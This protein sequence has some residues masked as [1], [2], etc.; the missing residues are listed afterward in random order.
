MN[1][2]LL[3]GIDVGTHA[4]KG[5]IINTS[6][7]V[8]SYSSKEHRVIIPKPGWA[9]HDANDWWEDFVFISNDLI[10]KS[11]VDPGKIAA[12]GCSA[13][14]PTMMPLDFEGRP[15]R[16]AIL[17]G[18]DN[19]ASCEISM[20]TKKI[21]EKNLLKHNGI[22]LSS[23]SAGPKILWF[24]RN[25]PDLFEKTYKIVTASTYLVYKLT[26]RFFIDYYTAGTFNP[27]FDS[28]KLKWTD[29][30]WNEAPIKL[31]PEIRWT[32]DIA[33]EI[34]KSVAKKTGLKEG[35]KVIVGTA[36]AASE[37][38][39][40]GVVENGDLMIMLGTSAFFIQ[41]VNK[42]V[43]SIKVWPT[44]YLKPGMYAIAAAMSS[45]GAI[46]SWLRELLES[47]TFD[48]IDEMV[49]KSPIGNEGILALPYFSGERTPIN[50][51]SA[52]GSILGL[53]L[54]HKKEHITRAIFE[55]IAYGI[56]D[57]LENIEKACMPIRRNIVIGG[58]TKNRNLMQIISNVTKKEL[59]IPKIN[60]GACFGNAF[61]AG[62]GVG[63]FQSMGDILNWVRWEKSIKPQAEKSSEYDKYYKL[64]KKFYKATSD[65]VHE[66]VDLSK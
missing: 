57:N 56:R 46:I 33:G 19:R 50:D 9:E 61:L 28:H 11:N 41:I 65:I 18:I 5:V 47:Y 26:G 55:S 32:A 62:L 42:F 6:G 66:L 12:V 8:K 59:F 25:E 14:A 22:L 15:L 40:S 51:P 1:D 30:L 48:Q 27:V 29:S 49:E 39:S 54:Y 58:V 20:M 23:Q 43:R 60:Y 24:M 64:Y 17:Y 35:T 53:S 10:R 3:L 16:K 63:V 7:D 36:D 21:G 44:V 52:R 31:L 13:I 4:S 38:V 37:A 34:T 2:K 45:C